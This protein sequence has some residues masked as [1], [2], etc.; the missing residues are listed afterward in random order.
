MYK[1]VHACVCVCLCLFVSMCVHFYIR[2]GVCAHVHICMC[3][4]G[5]VLVYTC[6]PMYVCMCICVYMYIQLCLYICVCT[7]VTPF[8]K[9]NFYGTISCILCLVTLKINHCWP[10]CT[11]AKNATNWLFCSQNPN[12][13]CFSHCLYCRA[14]SFDL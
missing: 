14:Y 5:S 6:M 4:C 13:K 3:V 11:V 8:F 10:K 12:I 9:E 7:I 1:V 2:M